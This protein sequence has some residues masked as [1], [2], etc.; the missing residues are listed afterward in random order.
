MPSIRR[1]AKMII[2]VLITIKNSPKV[3]TVIG[4]ESTINIGLRNILSRLT[5]KE[6]HKA[7]VKS[8]T[9]ICGNTLLSPKMSKLVIIRFR[10]YFIL[11]YFCRNWEAISKNSLGFSTCTQW[12]APSTIT[13][14]ALGKCC[15][16]S[17]MSSART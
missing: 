5:T 15:L 16:I 17:T 10:I 11:V 7:S 8:L 14:V 13:S 12:P 2:I 6:N 3:T 1:S 9:L 4:K